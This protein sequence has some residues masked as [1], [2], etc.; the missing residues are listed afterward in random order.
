L[1]VQIYQNPEFKIYKAGGD[2]IIHNTHKK[3]KEGH[4]HVKR[5]DICMVMIK[6]IEKKQIPK[7]KSKYFIESLIRISDDRNY[8]DKISKCEG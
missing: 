8:I 5:Y 6:L 3:F 2:Y 7:S 4:T 1:S